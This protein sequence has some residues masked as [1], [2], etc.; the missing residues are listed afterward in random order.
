MRKVILF[1]F[2]GTIADSLEGFFDMMYVLAKKYRFRSVSREEFD[3]LRAESAYTVLKKLQ[4]PWYKIPFIAR[5]M[6]R[7]QQA[8]ID[9]LK[10]IKGIIPV[11]KIL[12]T[13]YDLGI[14]TS[15]SRANVEAFLKK[16]NIAFF[17]YLHTDSSLF[18]KDKILRGFLRKY[19]LTKDDVIYVG[20]EIRD[21]EACQKVG[22]KI[23]AVA[24]GFT[25]KKGLE[26]SKPNY[27]ID[28]PKELLSLLK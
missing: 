24:W 13:T 14:V 20:D 5:D 22:I 15:N 3:Q 11:I 10:S 2:D 16:N 9:N 25:I 19:N 4:I 1:D 26:K 7:M 28:H 27:T 18:G 12:K 23:I 6:K 17:H 8:E 21:I